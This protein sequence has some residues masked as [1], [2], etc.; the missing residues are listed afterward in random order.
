MSS[1]MICGVITAPIEA[2]ALKDA[3]PHGAILFVE[4]GER[5][6][7]RARPVPRLE[8]AEQGP[9]NQQTFRIP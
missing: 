9:A 5:R 2:L 3:V 1:F 6:L 8:K 4:Q 7:H